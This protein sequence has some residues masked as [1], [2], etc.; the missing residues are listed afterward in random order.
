MGLLAITKKNKKNSSSSSM[1]AELLPEISQSELRI[2]DSA[3][4]RIRELLDGHTKDALMRVAIVGGG[5][6]GFSYHFAIED[7]A[8]SSDFIFKN[9]EVRICVDPKSLKILGGSQLEWHEELGSNGF[10]L[11]NKHET[12][13]CSCGKS[14]SL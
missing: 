14:F 1:P 4:K 2:A 12:K 7:G 9:Q 6:S 8:A 11:R 3:A 5:C 13:S 10:R